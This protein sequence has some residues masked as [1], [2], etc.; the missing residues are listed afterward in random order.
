MNYPWLPVG[1]THVMDGYKQVTYIIEIC[2]SQ[3]QF[4]PFPNLHWCIPYYSDILC[5]TSLWITG[6]TTICSTGC[7][8]YHKE[9]IKLCITGPLWGESRSH[10]LIQRRYTITLSTFSKMIY[11]RNHFAYIYLS[12]LITTWIRNHMPSKAWNYFSVEVLDWISRP[13]V[14]DRCNCSSMLDLMLIHVSE[15]SPWAVRL[16]GWFQWL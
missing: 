3:I 5:I 12:T 4:C 7:S 1:F 2:N 8:N 11:N 16:M 9:S 10:W 15:R 13:T 6:Y 14:S